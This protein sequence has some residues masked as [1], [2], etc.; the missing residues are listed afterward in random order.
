MIK[1]RVCVDEMTERG[2]WEMVSPGRMQGLS[3]GEDNIPHILKLK[4]VCK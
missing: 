2:G 1:V 3:Y 4:E